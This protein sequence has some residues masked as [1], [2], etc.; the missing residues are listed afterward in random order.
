[1]SV[2]LLKWYYILPAISVFGLITVYFP[3]DSLV[4]YFVFLCIILIYIRPQWGFW[5]SVILLPVYNI[6]FNIDLGTEMRFYFY[7]II[8]LLTYFAFVMNVIDKK[9]RKHRELGGL[10]F[11]GIFFV[12]W[13]GITLLWSINVGEGVAIW[14]ELVS[15]LFIFL[16]FGSFIRTKED[17]KRFLLVWICVGAFL[18]SMTFMSKWYWGEVHYRLLDNLQFFISLINEKDRAAGFT[19]VNHAATILNFVIV[20]GTALFLISKG[21]RRIKL[22]FLL[23]FLLCVV[24]MTGSKSGFGGLIVSFGLL[25]LMI[26]GEG[27]KIRYSF[28]TVCCLCAGVMIGSIITSG[29][30]T[31]ARVTSVGAAFSFET[32]FNWWSKG[33]KALFETYGIGVGIGGLREIISPVRYAHNIF[34]SVLFDLGGIGFSIFMVLLIYFVIHSWAAMKICRDQELK[35][36]LRL[37]A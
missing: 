27:K 8:I 31:T 34:L 17:I 19:G 13:S 29:S 14:L 23:F 10:Y 6:G 28:I 36:F 24:V 30:V 25:Y 18:G 1:M 4:C 26:P 20:M 9:R 15:G 7:T 16:L 5:L 12:L 33:F 21:G 3:I 11:L 35:L 37:M 32:R 22:F 2:S